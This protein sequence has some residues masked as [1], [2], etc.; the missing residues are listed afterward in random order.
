MKKELPIVH[1]SGGKMY[2]LGSN[3]S[4][5][6]TMKDPNV[7]GGASALAGLGAGMIDTMVDD[8]TDKFAG[9]GSGALKGLAAGAAFGPIGM[10]AGAVLGG[11]TGFFGAKKAEEAQLLADNKAGSARLKAG[12]AG[13]DPNAHVYA[14]GG[15]IPKLTEFNEGGSHEE[16]PLGGIPQGFNSSNGQPNLVEQGETKHKDYIFSDRLTMNNPKD[17][18]LG[19]DLK[20]KTFADI[21]KK[22]SKIASERPNDPIAQKGQELS[23]NRLKTANDDAIAM[24]EFEQSN[25]EAHFNRKDKLSGSTFSYGGFLFKDIS[26]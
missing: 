1:C 8:P 12:T 14:I 20:G 3:L 10:A 19:G 13:V 6:D 4:F 18:N 16:N 25:P 17:Y 21:S 24:A 5:A 26:R 2:F 15:M 22:L 9:A 23:L 7:Q 11:A